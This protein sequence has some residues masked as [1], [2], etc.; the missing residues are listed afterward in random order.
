MTPPRSSTEHVIAF[1]ERQKEL[2]RKRTDIYLD[3]RTQERIH[4][5]AKAQNQ[6]KADTLHACLVLG[7]SCLENQV[8]LVSPKSLAPPE[9]SQ[10]AATSW[11]QP[12]SSALATQAQAGLDGLQG[13]F[14]SGAAAR[15]TA[16]EQALTLFAQFIQ[17]RKNGS[18]TPAPRDQDGPEL[19]PR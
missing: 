12:D 14:V 9:S 11:G 3:T 15:T 5:L 1:R 4:A 18:S 10:P 17:Q 7:L 8:V 16:S 13:P 2:G 19:P 6:D